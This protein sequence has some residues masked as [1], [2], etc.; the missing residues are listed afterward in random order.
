[1]SRAAHTPTDSNLIT[2]AKDGGL[3]FI[4]EGTTTMSATLNSLTVFTSRGP[5]DLSYD[6]TGSYYLVMGGCAY[7]IPF[8]DAKA[9]AAEFCGAYLI[10]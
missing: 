3:H 6:R 8:L 2:A 1:M 10:R 5:L 9:V 7:F 4:N